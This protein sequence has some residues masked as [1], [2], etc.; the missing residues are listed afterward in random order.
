MKEGKL[1][2]ARKGV[3]SPGLGSREARD[4]FVEPY[5]VALST[6]PEAQL[7]RLVSCVPQSPHIFSGSLRENSGSVPKNPGSS[8]LLKL[9]EVPRN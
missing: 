2:R 5:S 9:K 3:S 4:R 7:R 1:A 6:L 8:I